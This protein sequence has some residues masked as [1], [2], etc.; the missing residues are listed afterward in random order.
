MSIASQRSLAHAIHARTLRLEQSM[1]L[2]PPPP[3]RIHFLLRSCFL[4]LVLSSTIGTHIRRCCICRSCTFNLLKIQQLVGGHAIQTA[5]G[6]RFKTRDLERTWY[7]RGGSVRVEFFSPGV[8]SFLNRTIEMSDHNSGR[9]TCYV[10]IADFQIPAC[11]AAAFSSK[12]PRN[13]C[14]KRMLEMH[15]HKLYRDATGM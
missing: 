5:R 3:Q 15:G 10:R 14:S 1:A 8:R 11:V 6:L 7:S 2:L 9:S 4:L 12:K 13:A